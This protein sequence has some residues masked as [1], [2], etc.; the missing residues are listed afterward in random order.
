M[1]QSDAGV[2]RLFLDDYSA[3]GETATAPPSNGDGNGDPNN[4]TDTSGK[5]SA[6]DSSPSDSESGSTSLFKIPNFVALTGL[7]MVG[8]SV[9]P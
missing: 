3:S 6:D 5:G 1:I 9:L 4:S 7:V 8:I 2:Q